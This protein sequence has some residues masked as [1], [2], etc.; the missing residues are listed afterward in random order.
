MLHDNGAYCRTHGIIVPELTLA[1]LP[2]PYRVPAY[3]GRVQVVL[4][5]KTPCGTYRAPGRFEGS[6]AREQL[7]DVAA[8]PA[9]NRPGRDALA[10][11]CFT[12]GE[13]PC[14]R[15]MSTLGTDVVLDA[16]DYPG[17]AGGG[18]GRSGPARLPRRGGAAGG[19][20]AGG[21]GSAWPRSWRRAGSARR[22]PR[23]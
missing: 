14:Q 11:T 17:A 23:T 18:P 1:M 6:A 2:G 13:L 8:Q 16:G 15:A 4:T 7:L 19:G 10:A 12:P 21:A 20:P 22:R 5:S 3:R 9:R